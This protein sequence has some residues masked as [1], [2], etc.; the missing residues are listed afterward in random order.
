MDK[1]SKYALTTLILCALTASC[2]GGGGG[3]STQGDAGGKDPIGKG[4][5]LSGTSTAPGGIVADS[6]LND[7]AADYAPNDSIA[8]A[9]I[10]PN[11][12]TVVGYL[13]AA[14]FGDD[15]GR[16]ATERDK[17]DV[18]RM[19]LAAGQTI[20]VEMADWKEGDADDN[21]DIDIYLYNS[22]GVAVQSA[23][24]GDATEVLRVTKSGDYYVT[25]QA[26]SG[27][28]NYTMQISLDDSGMS[29]ASSLSRFDDFV[30]GQMVV[31][32][33]PNSAQSRSVSGAYSL[34]ERA[35]APSI[36]LV[37][38]DD[39]ATSRTAAKGPATD[40]L[41]GATLS[42][43]MAAKVETIEKIKR[44]RRENPT[45]RIEPN[46]LLQT[47]ALPNDP[48]Y[49]LQWHYPAISLPAAWD[50][51][52]GAGS[53]RAIVAVVDTGIV[54]NHPDLI[55]QTV[56]GYDFISDPR[57]SL[58][59]DGIDSDA[60]DP[61]TSPYPGESIWHGTHVAGTV[62][63]NNNNGIGIAGVAPE[64]RVMPI[65]AL[66]L[67]GSGSA[68]DIAQGILY[69]AGLNNASGTRPPRAADIINLSL[70]STVS[71]EAIAEAVSAAQRAGSIVVAAA[72]N[73]ATDAPSYPAAY[74]G[75]FSVGATNLH[76][77]L[78]F[79][80]NYGNSV[81]LAA[82]G[83]DTTVDVDG[84]GYPDGILSTFIFETATSRTPEYVFQQGTS[85][86]APHVAGVFAL[87]KAANPDIT[88]AQIQ[89]LVD[90]G[91]ITDDLGA[92]GRDY[93]FGNGLINAYKAVLGAQSLGGGGTD[94]DPVLVPSAT[95]L[96]FGRLETRLP[97][98]LTPEGGSVTDIVVT[99]SSDWVQIG[100]PTLRE[101]GL[102]YE[103]GVV[104]SALSAGIHNAT[105]RVESSAE[106]LEI[107]VSVDTT[108]EYTAGEIGPLYY[109]LVEATSERV[110]L[111]QRA[112][113]KG[114]KYHLDLVDIDNGSY[115]VI[116]GTD[117][118]HDG[119]ICDEGEAC[120]AWPSLTAIRKIDASTDHTDLNFSVD[121]SG[122]DDARLEGARFGHGIAVSRH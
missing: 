24:G 74:A 85:M 38:T 7:P 83:G 27:T 89:T 73:S 86:A 96:D 36:S 97:L 116:A 35:G 63:A 29:S 3:S 20:R 121:F 50:I 95:S 5:K 16:F 112:K 48:L 42:D 113:I 43:E 90:S 115:Y 98:R 39:L 53:E 107:T 19:P 4:V 56:A 92:P 17:R 68:Y 52:E 82:P 117:R 103:I 37:Q 15:D 99:S 101:G 32:E 49:A 109:L 40:P 71:A 94:P 6:D 51:T 120:G 46:Y 81:D 47:A 9:Q 77:E 69:A 102:D 55:G 118:D 13:S 44:A 66:G 22:D 70:G 60:T 12:G 10:A 88:A 119:K 21:Q 105:L 61:G 30:P 33:Q 78:T 59:G 87:M 108:V 54:F 23:E 93:Y 25:L 1:Q 45:S 72:G 80:S 84:N 28:G 57:I 91:E 62:V 11:P 110:V 79:Y 100:E 58:D 122:T 75:V 106:T 114:G 8:E 18:Y 2:G 111:V 65:R 14:G 26:Y 104:R 76:N 31:L 67:N 41:T 34:S 64:A